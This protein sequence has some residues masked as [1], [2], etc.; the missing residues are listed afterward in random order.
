VLTAV[1]RRERRV[2]IM[3]TV[4]FFL[5]LVVWA[6]VTPMLQAPNEA[7]HF[8][9]VLQLALGNGW[10]RPGDLHM[11][12][13]TDWISKTAAASA[14]SNRSTIAAI[15]AAHPGT[16][17]SVDPMTQHPPV[18]Y[19]VLA[20]AAKVVGYQHLRWDVL[21][22]GL[23]LIDALVVAPLPLFVWAAAR[24]LTAMRRLALIAPLALFAV[25]ELAQVSASVTVFAPS[26]L[27][28][29]VLVWLA[30]RVLTRADVWASTVAMSVVAAAM[31]WCNA[32][33]LPAA[34]FAAI[35]PLF[36]RGV[37]L[38]RRWIAAVGVAVLTAVLGGW[39]YL[40]ALLVAGMVQPDGLAGSTTPANWGPNTTRDIGSFLDTQWNGLTQTFWGDLG[41]YAYPL[42]PILVDS[43]SVVAIVGLAWAYARL[44]PARREASV[45]LVLPGLTLVAILIRNWQSY[46][47]IH[48]ISS[49]E[50]RLLFSTLAA[51]VIVQAAGWAGL[52]VR[53]LLRRR[54]GHAFIVV[55]TV[56]GLYGFS[57][58]YRGGYEGTNLGVTRAGL[59]H[60]K[61][62]APLGFAATAAALVLCAVAAAIALVETWR[63]VSG[64]P[65]DGG[66]DD[67]AGSRSRLDSSAARGQ[68]AAPET[69]QQTAVPEPKE[70]LS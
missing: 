40:H 58:L 47:R 42:S 13:A 21:V 3:T 35:V 44:F 49:L 1:S 15:L 45:L 67:R 9:A 64:V 41:S 17:G 10:P 5:L 38:L 29:G 37:P 52:I 32:L 2:I 34:L 4:A 24:R 61:F 6:L 48:T 25:P 59:A 16:V 20:T 62:L 14:P 56:V 8:D 33:G 30:V 51:L 19:A 39:W 54:L 11:L 63:V 31:C 66:I 43:L 57:L 60:L 7:A 27:L 18:W 28:G 68:A 23:R 26:I 65:L 46:G 12:A 50:G 55:V 53:P 70:P 36:V 22:V 69:D